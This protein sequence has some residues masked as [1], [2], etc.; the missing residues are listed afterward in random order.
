MTADEDGNWQ[1]L[2]DKGSDNNPLPKYRF[3]S[4]GSYLGE[5]VYTVGEDTSTDKM[6]S[7]YSL[8]TTGDKDN[9]YTV[10]NT[11]EEPKYDLTI[12]V[13]K[14]WVLEPGATLPES[15]TV[16]LYKDGST[17]VVDSIILTANTD[18]DKDWKGSFTV[19]S[20]DQ[21]GNDITYYV[22]EVLPTSGPDDSHF[23]KVG[24]TG[25]QADGFTI[26]NR[27]VLTTV[28]FSV[29]KAWVDLGASARQEVTVTPDERRRR[30]DGTDDYP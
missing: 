4:D 18:A 10:T 5:V 14:E 11:L 28:G 26:V 12:S 23:V 19:E 27:S 3:A 25:N 17:T 2:F 22:D 15:V 9:E 13:T 29:T 7:G 6:P 16:N 20:K 21:S 8:L 30:A 1:C 24:I